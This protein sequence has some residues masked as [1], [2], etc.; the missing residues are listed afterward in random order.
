MEKK[1]YHEINNYK[2]SLFPVEI[3]RVS[4]KGVI[5]FGRGVRDFHWHDELQFTLVI[6]GSITLQADARQYELKEGDAAFINSGM[7]HAVTSLSKGGKYSS[8][9]FPY[10]LLS[11]FPGSRM[12][13]EYVLPYVTGGCLPV[14]ILRS[15]TKVQEP[16]LDILYEINA[17]WDEPFRAPNEYFVATKI[18]TLW[19]A[20]LSCWPEERE[21]TF[22]V[23]FVHR[24][25]LQLMLSFIYEHFSEDIA[26]S[27]IADAAHISVG[28]CC[29]TFREHLQTTPYQ[30]LTEYRIH[31]S[32]EMLS[33]GLSISEIAGSCGYNQTSNY[34]AKFRTIMGCTPAQYRKR[35]A[36][37]REQS[38]GR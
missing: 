7:I 26:L 13:K 8:L 31:K 18:V 17:L 27:D 4:E 2:D 6:H 35:N 11:F 25:R 9:N 34:I 19:H 38:A 36:Q 14:I 30:F 5:P 3:Y 29:R 22:P 24:Q 33:G 23:D 28:E 15:G 10:K 20:L 16:A 1:Q 21:N 12:E 37:W 32:M